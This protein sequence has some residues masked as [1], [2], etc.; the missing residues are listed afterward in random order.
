[1]LRVLFVGLTPPFPPTNGHRLRDWFLLKAL[2]QEGHEV[3]LISFT[4]T[5]VPASSMSALEGVCASIELIQEPGVNASL[6]E[7]C[8][9][10][11][12]ASVTARP[13]GAWRLRSAAMRKSIAEHLKAG[14]TDVII[15]DDIYLAQNVPPTDVP[16]LINKHDI[17][18][19][20][21]RRYLERQRNPIVRA[22][23]YL[24][25]SK[26]K[27]WELNACRHSA[28]VLA[29]SDLD[30]RL[31]ADS[32]PGVPMAVAPNIVDTDSYAPAGPGD[33]S[34]L[35]YVGAM[36]WFPN[37]DA[38]EHFITDTLPIVRR[39]RPDVRLVVA[40]RNPS[41]ALLRKFRDV[42]GVV[43][44]GAVEDI[45]EAIGGAAVSIVPLRIGSGT[46]LKILEAAAMGKAI[47]STT[48]GAEGLELAADTEIILADRP[49]AFARGVL[50]LLADPRRRDRM[51]RAARER[52]VAQYSLPVL[53]RAL[54]G[55]LHG[56]KGGSPR[57][58]TSTAVPA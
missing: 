6:V 16:V 52:V 20:I 38:V 26:L 56:L 17:T 24:E 1:M 18:H 29:C 45:R 37:Q 51:G 23:G 19:V 58:T 13:Y 55:A 48:L 53:R 8:R 41:A 57:R 5:A 14:A 39:E 54:H 50:N 31:L 32:C 12:L 27:R 44:T 9:G 28:G 33:A 3:A 10:R 30:R 34:T 7:A 2:A 36:D 4:A 35:I 40:G 46:R 49:E 22:Y 11:L 15:C 43:F 42:P 21:V 25:Y 47:V